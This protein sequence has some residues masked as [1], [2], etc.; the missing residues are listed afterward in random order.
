MARMLWIEMINNEENTLGAGMLPQPR[1]A[2]GKC[3]FLQ[4]ISAASIFLQ[5]M[6]GQGADGSH[7]FFVVAVG[8]Q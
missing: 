1:G 2:S 6:G 4:E 5:K 8:L 7:F 3:D